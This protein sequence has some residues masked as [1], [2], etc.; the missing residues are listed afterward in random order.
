VRAPTATTYE[1]P[2]SETLIDAAATARDPSGKSVERTLSTAPDPGHVPV[3]RI[4]EDAPASVSAAASDPA[5][6]AQAA[7]KANARW[8]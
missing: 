4:W 8:R 5:Q 3:A 2:R 1:S 7:A 6:T